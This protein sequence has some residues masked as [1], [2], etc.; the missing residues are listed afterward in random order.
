M[1]AAIREW[2]SRLK[3][4]KRAISL[5]REA[6]AREHQHRTMTGWTISPHELENEILI[7]TVTFVSGKKP[8]PRSWWLVDLTNES[9]CE[10]PFDEAKKLI[11]IPYW[12]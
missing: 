10:L 8:P 12:R 2:F 4:K 1:I 5:A 3:R 9:A 11:D 6:F 7:V